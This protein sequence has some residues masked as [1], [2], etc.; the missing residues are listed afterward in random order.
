ML[1]A[2]PHAYSRVLDDARDLDRELTEV[3]REQLGFTH[4]HVGAAL[5]DR[6]QLPQTVETGLTAHHSWHAELAT[7]DVGGIE[8]AAI[9]ASLVADLL[10]TT[11]S[12]RV[13]QALQDASREF[14]QVEEESLKKCLLDLRGE[15]DKNADLLSADVSQ[16]GDTDAI[17]WQANH[18]LLQMT[19]AAQVQ[20]QQICD[21]NTE[22]REQNRQL[23][24][25]SEDLRNTALARCPDR[26]TESSFSER[27]FAPR[28]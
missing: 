6:W 3:E 19:L 28:D 18:Q 26:S 16:L 24:F 23:A 1:S 17:L 25:Q 4:V 20:N 7:T 27:I 11:A 14:F 22:L 5:V 8:K 2:I 21:E 10:T 9:V 12:G 15:V 13:L